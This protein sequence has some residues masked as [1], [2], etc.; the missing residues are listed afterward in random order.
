MTKTHL[1]AFGRGGN[2]IADFHFLHGDHHAIN[3]QL[4]QLPFLLKGDLLEAMTDSLTK[5][6]DGARKTCQLHLLMHACFDLTSLSVQGLQSLLY[7]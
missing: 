2:H 1:L 4:Y 3:K 6:S 5:L 7:R